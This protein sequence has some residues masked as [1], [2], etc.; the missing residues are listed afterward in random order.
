MDDGAAKK[1]ANLRDVAR[2]AGVSVATVSRVLNAPDKVKNAT[3]TRVELKIAELEFMPSAAA[4]AFSTGRSRVVGAIV[5]TLDNAIFSRV[6]DRLQDRLSEAGL[7]MVVA[8]TGE[9]LKTELQ[10]TRDLLNIGAE[11]LIVA[12]VTHDPEF[13]T[14]VDRAKIPVVAI[15]Y[16]DPAHAFPTVGYDNAAS[17]QLAAQHLIDHGHRKVAVLHGPYDKSD[18]TR[19]RLAGLEATELSIQ[20]FEVDVSAA[21]GALAIERMIGTGR[22]FEACLSLS[23]VIATGALFELARRG[24]RVPKDLS[25]ISIDDLPIAETT[26]PRLTSVRLPVYQ[27]GEAA[28][29]ALSAWI[30]TGDRPMARLIP[31]RLIERASVARKTPD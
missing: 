12:G 27:M 6:L 16:F 9:D 28:A 29:E 8:T 18:R 24:V 1:R 2:A 30:A 26:E 7:S 13:E 19:A 5:P 15:S 3:R 22:R 21:G 25:V 10:K 20:R 11:G 17:A 4:R 14:L 23:D 31:S